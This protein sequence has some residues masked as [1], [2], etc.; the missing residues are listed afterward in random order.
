[1]VEGDGGH[2]EYGQ[3]PAARDYSVPHRRP[4]HLR[5]ER[6]KRPSRPTGDHMDLNELPMEFWD[7]PDAIWALLGAIGG[8]A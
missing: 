3:S 1:M 5:W 4:P 6:N 2:A 8:A 7:D